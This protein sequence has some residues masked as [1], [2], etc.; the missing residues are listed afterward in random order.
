[1]PT[2]PCE[3]TFLSP[4]RKWLH[5]K[6]LCLGMIVSSL[7]A[8]RPGC[9]ATLYSRTIYL[10]WPAPLPT[11]LLILQEVT[12]L[13]PKTAHVVILWFNLPTKAPTES[14]MIM[15]ATIGLVDRD[16]CVAQHPLSGK[17][18]QGSSGVLQLRRNQLARSLSQ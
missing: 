17:T 14:C 5:C 16:H 2:I 4:R 1:M 9:T 6:H 3:R 12:T 10:S 18:L 13:P 8:N 11:Q 7:A 15:A